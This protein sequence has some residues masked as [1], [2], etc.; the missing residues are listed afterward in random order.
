MRHDT[1]IIWQIFTYCILHTSSFIQRN[2]H[3][4]VSA[5]KHCPSSV[6]PRFCSPTLPFSVLFPSMV[7]SLPRSIWSSY[8]TSDDGFGTPSS[9]EKRKPFVVVLALLVEASREPSPF[10]ALCF[11]PLY[12]PFIFISPCTFPPFSFLNRTCVVMGRSFWPEN[13]FHGRNDVISD[14]YVR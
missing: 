4:A 7:F 2:S 8:T 12:F 11:P 6:F 5:G 10:P 1:S 14:N 13:I 3:G 9:K